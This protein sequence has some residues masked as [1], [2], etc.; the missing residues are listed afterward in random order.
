MFDLDRWQE[1]FQTISKNKL[2]S[3]LSGFTITFAILLFTILLGLGNGLKNTFETFF[4]DDAENAIY[5][6]TWKTSKPYKGLQSGRE[7]KLKNE[8]FN[9]VKFGYDDKV[10]YIT[11]RIYK[12]AKVVY[13]NNFNNYS[14]RG[15]HPDHQFLEKTLVN[16]GRY[17]NENDLQQRLKVA[18]IGR[19]VEQD[20]FQKGIS[21]VGKYI[22]ISGLAYKVIGVFSDEGGDNEERIAYIPITTAQLIYGNS[23]YVDQVNLTYNPDLKSKE[24]IK[25]GNE[26]QKDLR[27]R[28]LIE[29]RDQS[30]LRVMN[31]AEQTQGTQQ[32]FFALGIIVFFIGFGTLIAGIVGISNIMVYIV[33]ERTKELGIRKA[34][35]ATPQSI[36]TM[37]LFESL[38]I[39]AIAGYAG[40]LIGIGVL[41]LLGNSFEEYYITNPGVDTGIV[42][43]A[44]IMLIFSGV[45]AGYLPAKRA[46][47]IKPIVALRDE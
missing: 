37:V 45:V 44:T 12:D 19:L 39:T 13:K 6:R 26:L 10:Q 30:A 3:V 46:A 22:N 2:R 15:V 29:P 16:E 33:K 35:G 14:L 4:K 41:K 43:L 32:T 21:A 25:F 27:E 7:I 11:A 9:F 20:L 36:V 24:A 1:I 47:Q 5:I 38:F 31:M 8:D 34:L 28:L 17:L 18:V 40:L 42:V 23:E